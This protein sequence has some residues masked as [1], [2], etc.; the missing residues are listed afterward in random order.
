MFAKIV[1]GTK[2]AGRGHGRT[3]ACLLPFCAHMLRLL[4][5]FRA[6]NNFVFVGDDGRT[7]AMRLGFAKQPLDLEDI[8]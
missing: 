8:V 6:V 5:I 4:T 2:C 3:L 7:P 1:P